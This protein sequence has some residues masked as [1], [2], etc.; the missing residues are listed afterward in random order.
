MPLADGSESVGTPAGMAV[1]HARTRVPID[2]SAIWGLPGAPPWSSW[3]PLGPSGLPGATFGRSWARFGAP[4]ASFLAAQGRLLVDLG[5]D[6]GPL[7]LR[8]WPLWPSSPGAF[9]P[10]SP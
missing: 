8:F 2:E 5:L 7:G 4:W 3:P 9:E 6:L 1:L 10:W